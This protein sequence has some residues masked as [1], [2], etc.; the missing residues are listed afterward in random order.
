MKFLLFLFALPAMSAP[1]PSIEFALME[2]NG[3]RVNRILVQ[4]KRGESALAEACAGRK[5]SCEL[6]FSDGVL[7]QSI[8]RVSAEQNSVS[9][10][11]LPGIEPASVTH[12]RIKGESFQTAQI[13]VK[14]HL[15]IGDVLG[16]GLDQNKV[17]KIL[18]YGCDR[19][20]FEGEGV[21]PASVTCTFNQ[22]LG[23]ISAKYDF[24]LFLS[25]LDSNF[26]EKGG[27]ST[28]EN[29]ICGYTGSFKYSCEASP[30]LEFGLY[31]EQ[32][33]PFVVS[34]MLTPRPDGAM[35]NRS[36]GFAALPDAYGDCPA[37]LVKAAPYVAQPVSMGRENGYLPTSYV[38]NG[39]SLNN[40]VVSV[41]SRLEPFKVVRQPNFIPCD[42]TG[43]C[44]A[45]SFAEARVEQSVAYSRMSPTVCVI[46]RHML[47]Y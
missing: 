32:A 44:G 41:S 30:E 28:F 17:R 46:P 40:T 36:Y 13:R 45:V 20:F 15:E 12:V 37:G 2:A 10:P 27:D 33:G 16:I 29:S 22:R 18:R 35:S 26:H 9:C 7:E 34:V 47:L 14:Q 5:C 23:L 31:A 11:A 43:D 8:S 21:T 39:G 4:G 42:A 24:Y 25:N 1:A 19:T 38:S 3:A 6:Y